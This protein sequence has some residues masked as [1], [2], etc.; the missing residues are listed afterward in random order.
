MSQPFPAFLQ[1]AVPGL[2]LM[3]PWSQGNSFTEN[4]SNIYNYKVTNKISY[5]K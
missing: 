5:L 2:E 1:E 4:A 3:T